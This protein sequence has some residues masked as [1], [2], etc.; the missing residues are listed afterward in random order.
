MNTP[1][2]ARALDFWEPRIGPVAARRFLVYIWA[3]FLAL[4]IGIVLF[5]SLA[6]TAEVDNP[7][8]TAF[9]IIMGV[10][11]FTDATLIWVAPIFARRA[12]SRTLGVKVTFRNY[13]PRDSTEYRNWCVRNHLVPFNANSPSERPTT[14]SA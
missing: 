2:N 13:P 14:H 4:P 7:I 3:T 8:A 10:V 5:L 6:L 1:N 9:A 12:A 11:A